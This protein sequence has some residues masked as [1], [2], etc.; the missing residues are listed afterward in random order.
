MASEDEADEVIHHDEE[1]LINKKDEEEQ[2]RSRSE[3]IMPT[4]K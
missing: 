2:V 4:L 3:P 1:Q